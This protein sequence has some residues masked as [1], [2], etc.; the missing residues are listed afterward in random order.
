MRAWGASPE[1]LAKAQALADE[2]DPQDEKPFQL[3][4][5]NAEP[6]AVF[7]ALRTQWSYVTTGA[8][9]GALAGG[10]LTVTRVGLRYES[11]C[12]WL[13]THV[14]RRGKRRSLM[15]DLQA[16]EL[17]VLQAD[18]ELRAEKEE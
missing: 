2:A 15:N 11:V 18:A 8:T 12:A 16:M 17:A 14:P 5:E 6:W 4:P 7:F 10:V 3:W 1:D 13:E 9:G